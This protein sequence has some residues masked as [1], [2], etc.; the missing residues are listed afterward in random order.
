MIVHRRDSERRRHVTSRCRTG[1]AFRDSQYVTQ[2]GTRCRQ[3]AGPLPLEPQ[4]AYE[5]TF[6]LDGV[7]DTVYLSHR[8][9]ERY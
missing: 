2:N 3:G 1:T 4:L 7:K 5:I 6:D 8:D 9:I